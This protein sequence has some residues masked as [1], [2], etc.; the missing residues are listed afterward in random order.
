M[1]KMIYD[2]IIVEKKCTHHTIE[3]D[4]MIY[5]CGTVHMQTSFGDMHYIYLQH[6]LPHVSVFVELITIYY[7]I[8]FKLINMHTL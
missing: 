8:I 1:L 2:I 3:L 4:C 7:I 6:V 5:I